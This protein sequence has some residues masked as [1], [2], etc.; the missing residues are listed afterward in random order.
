MKLKI[1]EGACIGCGSCASMFPEAFEI[2][3][4]GL[5]RVI[6]ELNEEEAT[7]VIE[8]CPA[9]VISKAE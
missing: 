4:D 3:E 5:A 2:G 7:Q 1:E 9:G 8:S 6:G